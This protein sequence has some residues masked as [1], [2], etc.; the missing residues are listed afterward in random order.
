VNTLLQIRSSLFSDHG[1]SNQL[2]DRFVAASRQAHPGRLAGK[3]KIMTEATASPAPDRGFAAF[4]MMMAALMMLG[5]LGLDG[6]LPSL[7]TIARDLGI[8]SPNDRQWVVMV[9]GLSLGVGQIVYGP[10][11][12]RYGR[13]PVL[14]AGLA[15]F[16]VFSAIAAV[17]TSLPMLLVA[18][19]LQGLA[20][21]A[22]RVG[23]VSVI[24]DRYHGRR[25]A[26]VMSICMLVFMASPMFAPT[27]GQSVL[28]FASWR[29]LFGAL[30][31]VALSVAAWVGAGLSETLHPED[32]REIN[33][34]EV[35]QAFGMT[36]R[37]RQ[38]MGYTLAATLALG[39]LFGFINS[40]SQL[41]NDTL[42]A[43]RHFALVFGAVSAFTAVASLLN[44]RWVP[45]WGSRVLAHGALLLSI[46][47]AAIHSAIGL[48]G[49]ETLDS[50]LVLQGL[51]MFCFGLMAGNLGALA[52]EPMGHI[53]G[54]AASAQGFIT[55]VGGAFVGF[56]IG[57]AFD[58]TVVPLAGGSLVCGLA[59]LVLVAVTERGRLFQPDQGAAESAS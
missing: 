51:S 43:A 4:V 53:A 28:A 48:S 14:L 33:P 42:H 37:S 7:P 32:R 23:S 34:R 36:I 9:Y 52:M 17:A 56:A 20:I 27:L 39:T 8:R 25:M 13:K 1:Q 22:A 24:R 40:A 6:M 29:W 35:L 41:I 47:A 57:Q 10:L 18:R 58:G 5:A 44:A 12:D 45:R 38:G 11:M 2:A 31:L 21:A 54:S 15:G 16:A 46:G 59:A 55:T 30:A 19:S 49:H 50:F 26:Q 3:V